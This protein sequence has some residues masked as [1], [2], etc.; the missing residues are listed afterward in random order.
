LKSYPLPKKKIRRIHKI[1]E[2]KQLT[3]EPK[4]QIRDLTVEKKQLSNIEIHVSLEFPNIPSLNFF[5]LVSVHYIPLFK[6]F[7]SFLFSEKF[8]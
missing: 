2:T 4:L 1:S 7:S 6:N 3:E 8:S 5:G